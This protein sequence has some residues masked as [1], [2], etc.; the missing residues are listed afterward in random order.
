MFI[1]TFFAILIF[2]IASC[3]LFGLRIN[4]LGIVQFVVV[5]L[6][7]FSYIGIPA[8]YFE[9]DEFALQLNA[10]DKN[11]IFE[12][13]M[14]SGYSI[15]MVILGSFLFKTLFSYKDAFRVC[16]TSPQ[17]KLVAYKNESAVYF[18]SSLIVLAV[19]LVYLDLVPVVALNQLIR[20]AG[21][22]DASRS[23]MVNGFPGKYHWFSLFFQDLGLVLLCS[24]LILYLGNRSRTN[25]LLL[26]FIF[27]IQFYSAMMTLQKSTLVWLV[28]GM[29]FSYVI[30]RNCG[31]ISFWSALKSALLVFFGLVII[32]SLVLAIDIDKINELI[33]LVVSR[34]FA[35]SIQPAY[36]YLEM[37]PAYIDFLYGRSFPNPMGLFPHTP[38]ELNIE[39]M[40][41]AYPAVAK[42]DA[43]ATMPTVFWAELYANFGIFGVLVIPLFVGFGLQF[44]ESS[45]AFLNNTSL[46]IGLYVWLIMHYKNLAVTGLSQFVL[47]FNLIFTLIF[48]ALI[49]S[50]LRNRRSV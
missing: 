4:R 50:I 30:Y 35:G 25:L 20:G 48:I 41:F 17:I 22:L 42:S 37:F 36:H 13:M 21:D 46:K 5:S 18:F 39:V 19:L 15:F 7:F 14:L 29:Y 34:A 1:T 23:L 16:K 31:V 12:I 28:L 45:M 49:Y 32:F 8:L 24:S 44:I 43:V 27:L 40:Q 33:L 9:L 6:I 11:I 38:F 26:A 2:I 3:K 47:D 10:T